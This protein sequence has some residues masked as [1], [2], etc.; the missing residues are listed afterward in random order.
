[1]SGEEAEKK[2]GVSGGRRALDL[3][4]L[5][6]ACWAAVLVWQTRGRQLR[7]ETGIILDAL[8]P[9]R[10][11]ITY[12]IGRIDPRYGVSAGELAGCAARAAAV[13][14][15]AMGRELFRAAPSGGDITINMVYDQR[16][17]SMDKLKAMGLVTDQSLESYRSLKANYDE[18]SAELARRQASLAA[19]L[20]A[21]RRKAA[22]YNSV[23]EEY[24]RSGASPR[25]RRMFAERRSALEREFSRLKLLEASVN[26]RIDTLNALATALNQLIVRLRINAAQYDRQGAALGGTEEGHY[27]VD[28]G[29]RSIDVY[30]Y[31]DKAQLTR[32]LA[33]E[34]GHAL[35]L[36][37]V[38]DPRAIMAPVN[39]GRTLDLYPDD[40][41]EL[42]SACTS[43]LAR[44]KRK[45]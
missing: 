6:A 21:Y 2:S 37:H 25:Q 14:D 35:G 31:S 1:M 9:C 26:D 3:L 13:W 17:S 27:A 16:Q 28:G 20:E 45:Q 39:S 24:E 19:G 30:T 18:T 12:S 36:D 33:H 44:N 15:G 8:F 23:V 42:Y 38:A 10:F 40:L 43:P 29:F 4:L 11:P 41:A 5:A 34:L 22:E 7:S 32:L